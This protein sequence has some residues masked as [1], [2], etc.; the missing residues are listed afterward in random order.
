MMKIGYKN[1]LE[2]M[3]Q[4]L[5]QATQRL[6]TKIGVRMPLE[7]IGKSG[8]KRG[9]EEIGGKRHKR[10]MTKIGGQRGLGQ[11][12]GRRGVINIRGKDGVSVPGTQLVDRAVLLSTRHG[13]RHC[14]NGK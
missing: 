7:N 1:C 14:F 13:I 10:G 2:K 9:T 3:M 8:G 11:S 6:M 12:G 5:V 4:M